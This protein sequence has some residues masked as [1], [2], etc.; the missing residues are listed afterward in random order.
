MNLAKTFTNAVTR[1]IGRNVGK[2]ISNSFLGDSHSTPV[3]MTGGADITRKRGRVYHNDFDKFITKFEIKTAKTTY[4]QV[5]NIHSEYFTLVDEA[6]A[7]GIIDLNELSFLVEQLPRAVKTME[8][9]SM[10]LRDLDSPELAE[11]TDEKIAQLKE[12][13]T[14]LNDSTDISALP[15]TGLKPQAVVAFFLSFFG[16]DRIIYQPSKPVSWFF[17][18]LGLSLPVIIWFYGSGLFDYESLRNRYQILISLWGF[19]AL[20]LPFW[21]GM[22]LNPM[23]DGGYWGFRARQK[24][25]KL[26]NKLATSL[27]QL[28]TQQIGIYEAQASTA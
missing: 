23:R 2:S 17:A 6:Q 13:L 25:Q 1:E 8:K 20:T 15:S 5:L 22:L 14:T 21:Y 24:N 10:A 3:R 27:K 28:M 4:T 16:L 18:L 12:F 9:A 7:D 19:T 26:H 11:K